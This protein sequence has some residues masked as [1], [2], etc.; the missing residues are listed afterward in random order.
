MRFIEAVAAEELD[1]VEDLRR[2]F[3]FQAALDR[4][5]NELLA[6]L[7]DDVHLLFR[8]RLDAG[9]RGREFDPAKPVEDAHDLL[10]VDHDAVGLLKHVFHHGMFIVK[11]LKT[12]LAST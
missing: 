9:V 10:L 3:F 6:P 11:L 7:C 2:A 4:S 12:V 8:D 1:Q 5:F